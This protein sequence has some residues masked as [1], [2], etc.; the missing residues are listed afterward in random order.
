MY[1]TITAHALPDQVSVVHTYMSTVVLTSNISMLPLIWHRMCNRYVHGSAEKAITA[2]AAME[3]APMRSHDSP[4]SRSLPGNRQQT[5]MSDCDSKGFHDF[6]RLDRRPFSSRHGRLHS[7][8]D[9]QAHPRRIQRNSSIC[10]GQSSL[11][12]KLRRI[13]GMD[14]PYPTVKH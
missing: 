8:R 14:D 13:G 7:D 5:R 4:R 3:V 12:Q 2:V 10:V 6:R 9:R 11:D 1:I